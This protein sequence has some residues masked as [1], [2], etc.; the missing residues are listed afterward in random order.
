MQLSSVCEQKPIV[1]KQ[2]I[3][4]TKPHETII[5]DALNKLFSRLSIFRAKMYAFL[6][7]RRQ[8]DW[9][10]LDQQYT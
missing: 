6:V 10:L 1:K 9:T 5:F 7:S 2:H 8:D 3:Y 4:E